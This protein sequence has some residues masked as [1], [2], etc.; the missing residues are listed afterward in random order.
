M[1]KDGDAAR[2]AKLRADV[3]RRFR[4]AIVLEEIPDLVNACNAERG[5][6]RDAD[7][8]MKDPA[9]ALFELPSDKLCEE[10]DIG[11][12]AIDGEQGLANALQALDHTTLSGFVR[13]AAGATNVVAKASHAL[14]AVEHYIGRFHPHLPGHDKQDS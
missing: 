8:L 14:K 3:G 12:L 7:A 9:A 2:L 10:P 6:H 13:D 5:P 1:S 4:W 11:E